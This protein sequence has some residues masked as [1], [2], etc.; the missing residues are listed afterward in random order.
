[1][2]SI[3]AGAARLGQTTA[4]G[5]NPSPSRH[6]IKCRGGSRVDQGK[7]NQNAL[8]LAIEDGAGKPIP[9]QYQRKFS[10]E[11]KSRKETREISEVF[12]AQFMGME[13]FR[14]AHKARARICLRRVTVQGKPALI[15]VRQC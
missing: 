2:P 5:P 11:G 12:H 10:V 1:M 4:A 7:A 14:L 9:Y 6:A 13:T 15:A 3:V 8:M